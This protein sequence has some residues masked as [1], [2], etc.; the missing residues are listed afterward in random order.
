MTEG[1]DISVPEICSANWLE[2]LLQFSPYY[3]AALERNLFATRRNLYVAT[4]I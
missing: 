1:I 2:K 4:Q 3:A